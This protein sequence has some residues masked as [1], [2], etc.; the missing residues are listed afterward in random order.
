MHS[1]VAEMNTSRIR[2]V[3]LVLLGW[4]CFA[5]GLTGW[6]HNAGA[7]VVAITVWSLTALALLACWKV[8]TVRAWALD[9]DLRCLVLFHLT[10]LIAGI[11]FLALCHLGELPCAFALSAG[12]GDII[13]AVL[14]VVVVAA[15]HTQFT[16][17]FLLIW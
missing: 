14:A 2:F 12:W 6:F 9:V 5:V 10:R 3:I 7:P 16:K 4:L 8:G 15:M 17:T 11:Y 13:V 1:R